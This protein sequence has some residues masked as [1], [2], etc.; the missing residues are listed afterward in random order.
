M[1][2]PAFPTTL[3]ALTTS[4]RDPVQKMVNVGF[5]NGTGES[6]KK[7]TKNR[8]NFRFD[9]QATSLTQY[10]EYEAFFIAHK[11]ETISFIDFVDGSTRYGKM[12]EDSISPDWSHG[13]QNAKFSI[14]IN[15]I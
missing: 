10:L 13:K 14:A 5:E 9:L 11:G 6:R 12:L 1:S 2:Y 15:E 8:F 3:K 7:N 4:K